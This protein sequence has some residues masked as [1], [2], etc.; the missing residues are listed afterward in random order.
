VYTQRSFPDPDTYDPT[1]FERE[2]KET[3]EKYF[4]SGG[5]QT[6]YTFGQMDTGAQVLT[7]SGTVQAETPTPEKPVIDNIHTQETDKV[8]K[9]S[10]SEKNAVESYVSGDTMYINQVLRGR[11][12]EMTTEDKELIKDLDRALRNPIGETQMLYRSVDAEAV[13]G[14]MSSVEYDNLRSYIVYNDSM[15]IVKQNAERFIAKAQGKTIHELGYMSTTT[16]YEVASEWGGYTGSEKPIVLKLNTPGSI[17]GLALSDFE[18]EEEAQRE[19]LLSRGQR[20]NVKKVI[21]EDGNIV[22]YA[23]ILKQ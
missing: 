21:G 15:P 4:S 13:F 11:A 12:G 7:T 10:D 18:I 20:Y 14:K 9:L 8:S 19:V 23:D 1:T 2:Q 22:V 16:D 17:H 5:S 3:I 6:G